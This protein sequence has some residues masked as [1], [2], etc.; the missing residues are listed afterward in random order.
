MHNIA[1][2]ASHNGS[3]FDAIL[4]AIKADRLNLNI[5]LVVSNNT[6]AKVLQKAEDNAIK[7]E[8]VNS[9]TTNDVDKRLY[10]LLK[11]HK[12]QSIFLSGYMKKLSPLITQNFKVLNSHPSLL[13]KYGGVG[14]Y[15][16]SVHQ[17]VIQNREQVS[18]VTIHEVNEEYDSG[19]IILQKELNIA[20]DETPESLEAKIKSLETVTIV[21]ALIKYFSIS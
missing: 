18:G 2:F 7:T 15:G 16:F 5:A 14:M 4:N 10:E 11:H 13:P 17:A 20:K 9:K 19:E 6:N 21:E 8:V 1:V 12:C 3:G